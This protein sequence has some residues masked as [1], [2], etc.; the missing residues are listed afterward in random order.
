VAQ[1]QLLAIGPHNPTVRPV[2]SKFNF[3]I[4]IDIDICSQ[5]KVLHMQ[6]RLVAIFDGTFDSTRSAQ[7]F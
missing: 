7:P 4:D 3:D 5:D 1:L 2:S 6:V